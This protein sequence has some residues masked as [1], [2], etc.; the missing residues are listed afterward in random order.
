MKEET[1]LW[2]AFW[3][4]LI[5]ANVYLINDNIGWIVWIIL[6]TI[7]FISHIIFQKNTTKEKGE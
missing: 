5:I 4:L 2:I 1:H 6:A 7:A 3:G